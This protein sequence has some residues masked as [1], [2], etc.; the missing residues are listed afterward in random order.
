MGCDWLILIRFICL[1]FLGP[2][3]GVAILIDAAKKAI[4]T[5]LVARVTLVG[6]NGTLGTRI[7]RLLT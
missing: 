7:E 1:L 3:I 2:F 4:V 6:R 5:N